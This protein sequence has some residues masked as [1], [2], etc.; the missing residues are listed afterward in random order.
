MSLMPMY[1]F[2]CQK[3]ENK[4]DDLAPYD[5][6]GKYSKVKCP[7]CGSKKKIKL[8]TAANFKFSNPEGT[9]R[10]NS[11]SLGH[12]YR[13][14]HN[15]PKVLSERKKAETLSHMGSTPYKDTSG[16]DFNMGE[17]LHDPETRSGLV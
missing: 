5:E 1:D 4:Y 12:D 6:T 8:I 3:C 10:W 15:L 2:V 14:K 16:A 13:F 7:Y 17:G 9:D 11:A